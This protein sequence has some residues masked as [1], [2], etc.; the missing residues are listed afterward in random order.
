[1]RD[2]LYLAY[3]VAVLVVGIVLLLVT[4]TAGII[5]IVG[6]VIGVLMNLTILRR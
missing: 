1:M 3:S 6:G 2:R 5:L 4:G